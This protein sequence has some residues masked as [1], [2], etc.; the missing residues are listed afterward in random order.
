MSK[1]LFVCGS[2]NQT[3]QMHQIARELP[4]R[5]FDCFFTP[6]YVDGPLELCR[7][8]RLLDMTVAGPPLANRCLEYLYKHQ[9]PVD[10]GGAR[11]RYDLVF[12]CQD[13]V[14]QRNI[15]GVKVVLVQEGMTD[16]EKLGF[17][18][19]RRF[20]FLPRWLA[21]TASTGLS[22]LYDRFCVASEGYRD[23]FIEHGVRAE[24]LIVTGI[25]NFDDCERYLRNSFPHRDYLLACTSDARET[26]KLHSRR[27]FLDKVIRLA[28]GRQII[29]KLHPAENWARA[30]TE[31]LRV[32][33]DA[34]V[35]THGSAEEMVANCR[36]LLLEYSS[37][38]YVGLALGKEVHSEFPID[39]LRRLVPIQ[40]RRAASLIAQVGLELLGHGR[41]AVDRSPPAREEQAA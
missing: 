14:V 17:H 16:P 34:L 26:F 22:D 41:S 11:H 32:A 35:Y 9:L 27:R 7:R 21:G 15:R 6:Y 12:T 13:L 28:A 29:F 8:L 36:V 2:L 20:R 40:N 39:S 25:P 18:L 37:L 24:K 10:R 30:T 3:T 31:V 4:S 33:P 5:S 19:V 38:A 1:I 23:L